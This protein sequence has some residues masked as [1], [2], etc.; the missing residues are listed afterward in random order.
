VDV[1]IGASGAG[2]GTIKDPCSSCEFLLDTF[3]ESTSKK[4]KTDVVGALLDSENVCHS[5]CDVL[6]LTV[7]QLPNCCKELLFLMQT[8]TLDQQAISGAVDACWRA[9]GSARSSRSVMT[10]PYRATLA[11]VSVNDPNLRS[12]SVEY[13]VFYLE[14]WLGVEESNRLIQVALNKESGGK[15]EICI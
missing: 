7:G 10:F 15:P 1:N 11:V 12:E 4:M 8:H 13:F 9:L 6:Q 14:G 2:H 3:V 5:M